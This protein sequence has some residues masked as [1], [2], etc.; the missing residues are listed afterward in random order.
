MGLLSEDQKRAAVSRFVGH[1]A[2]LCSKCQSGQF[3]V[4]KMG[5]LI[6]SGCNPDSKAIVEL[7]IDSGVWQQADSDWGDSPAAESRDAVQKSTETR[8]DPPEPN[9]LVY[10]ST[11]LLMFTTPLP[12]HYGRDIEF[13]KGLSIPP[14]IYRQLDQGY[15]G[16][17]VFGVR[18]LDEPHRSEGTLR[19]QQIACEAVNAEVF[20]EWALDL[21][22]SRWPV[23][24]RYESPRPIGFS[25]VD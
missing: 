20:G 17:L 13:G 15:F 6:C 25:R 24:P 9:R 22:P 14:G 1:K 12:A 16:W 8:I 19:L 2:R 21:D 7:V 10:V 11:R 5:G 18:R 3:H 23:N 4:N